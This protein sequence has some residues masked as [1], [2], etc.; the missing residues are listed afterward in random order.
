MPVR[1]DL[2]DLHDRYVWAMNNPLAAQ[3]IAQSGRLVTERTSSDQAVQSG[4]AEALQAM[5]Q[6]SSRESVQDPWTLSRFDQQC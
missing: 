6:H 2:S 3:Q 4:V 5:E 1:V